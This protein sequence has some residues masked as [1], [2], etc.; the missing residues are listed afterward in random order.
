MCLGKRVKA[1]L[2]GVGVGVGSLTGETDFLD[3]GRASWRERKTVAKE[4][5][6]AFTLK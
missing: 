2:G 5:G 3:E 6:S 4:N 1:Q